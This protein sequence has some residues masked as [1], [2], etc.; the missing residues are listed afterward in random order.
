MFKIHVGNRSYLEWECFLE[1]DMKPVTLEKLDPIESKLLSGDVFDLQDNGIVSI[2]KSPS[3]KMDII[4]GVLDL[5]SNKTFG[6][7]KTGKKRLLYRV[8]PDDM[9][10]PV[11]LVPYEQKHMGFSK[12]FSNL[13]V[14]IKFCEWESKHPLAII[15][16][17]IGSVE[18][19]FNFY[20]YQLYCRSLY[21]SIQRF[22]KETTKQVR[23]LSE[24]TGLNGIIEQKSE[25]LQDR[26]DNGWNVFTIDPVNSVDFDDGFSIKQSDTLINISVYIANVTILM[27][28]MNLWDSFSTR[29]ATIYLPDRKRPM[30]PTI[31]SDS[32]CSLQEKVPRF[33]MTM[34]LF[35][36]KQTFEI[37]DVKY[38]NCVVRVSKNYRYQE[39][40]LMEMSDYVFLEQTVK[41]L[42]KKYQYIRN[43]QSSH[44][45]VGYLMTMMNYYCAKNLLEEKQGLFRNSVL[46]TDDFDIPNNLSAEIENFIKIWYSSGGQYID[47]S[48][49]DKNT[50]VVRHELMDMD[51]YIHITSPIRRLVDLL[52]MIK[53][54]EINKLMPL[55]NSCAEF[56]K[57]WTTVEQLDY[58]NTSMRSIRK[59]QSDCSMLEFYTNNIDIVDREY[60]GVLFDKVV[61]HD[62][63][64]KYVVY[65]SELKLT[66]RIYIPNEYKNFETKKFKLYLFHDEDSLKR[67]IRIQLIEN[68][69]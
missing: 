52:N 13:Y 36:D 39:K 2:K 7:E 43:I 19:L 67:K 28:H 48:L 66:T 57:K 55:S 23:K 27:D 29:V 59:I 64:F 32:L 60:D 56:Y 34:D 69:L 31:L 38:K 40:E 11:F 4:P 50:D 49:I 15:T 62:G 61:R 47:A 41:E 22:S 1:K 46:K 5:K 14:L 10:L 24:G 51:A 12:V 26:R 53:F 68:E 17:T 30:L 9:R 25:Y 37:K 16:A 65:L 58:I 20:E 6:R 44:D 63:M 45:V 18:V 3:R 42:S 8:V 21:A 35:I 54:Q 33:A